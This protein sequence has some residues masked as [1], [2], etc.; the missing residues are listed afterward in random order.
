MKKI[1]FVA[2]LVSFFTLNAQLSLTKNFNEPV[3]GDQY[4]KIGYDTISSISRLTGMGMVWNYNTLVIN[5]YSETSTY[6]TVAG[7]P[8]PGVFPLAT[9]AEDQ[10]DN[11]GYSMWRSSAAAWE[12]QGIQFPGTAVDFSNTAIYASWPM[13]YGYDMTDGFSGSGPSGSTTANYSGTITVKASGTGTVILP[14]GYTFTNCL[15]VTSTLTLNEAHSTNNGPLLEQSYAY[16]SS[17]HKFPI[18]VLRYI[19]RTNV[20]GTIKSFLAFVNAMTGPAN[21]KANFVRAEFNIYPNPSKE[22]ITVEL[23]FNTPATISLYNVLGVLVRE[24]QDPIVDLKE[25]ARGMYI[26]TI[27][28]NGIVHTRRIVVE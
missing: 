18:L 13:S 9:L 1:Y 10:G 6:T 14:G 28:Q 21:V 23:L 4:I 8:S 27:K 7:T 3:V 2:T 26:L 11:F 19:T 20:Q 24:Q 25:L 15:Q 5:S 17:T 16:Y 12:L 22:S